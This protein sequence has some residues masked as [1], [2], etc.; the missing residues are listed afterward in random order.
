MHAKEGEVRAR[1]DGELKSALRALAP[2]LL[3]SGVELGEFTPILSP[4][5]L[6][7]CYCLYE[8]AI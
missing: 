5:P 7:P 1:A 2:S 6:H 4:A 3:R 8:D